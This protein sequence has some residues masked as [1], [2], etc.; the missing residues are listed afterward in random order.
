[1]ATLAEQW[2]A[3]PAAKGPNFE[4]LHPDLSSRLEQAKAAYR[5]Q[6]GKDL[7]ITS[8]VRSREEQQRLYDDFKA[9]KPGIYMPTNPADQ[10]NKAVYH[11]DAVDI[12]SQVPESFLNQHGLHRP[13]GKKDPV[14]TVL[15]P[16]KEA[17]PQGKTL[18]DLWD[19]TPASSETAPGG[20]PKEELPVAAQ[21]YNQF[22]K[23]KRNI[24]EGIVGAGETAAQ[25]A[26]GGL[27]Y[28]VS[29]AG[30]LVKALTSGKY[31][32][33]EG[34]QAGQD[35]AR[36]I[37]EQM[38]YQPRTQA[39]Q[40][41]SGALGKAFEAS[42]LPPMGVPEL[43]GMAPLAG[44]AVQQ[45]AGKVAQIPAQYRAALAE[46][47]PAQQLQQQFQAKGGMRSGGAA[48]V[49]AAAELEAAIAQATP[50]LAA[51]LRQQYGKNPELANMEA[52]NRQLE[53]DQLLVPVRYTQG[54]ASQNP[55]LI[56]KERN[57]RGFKD[58]FVQRFNEQNK[59]LQ[60]NVNLVKERTAP[61]VFGPDYVSN[62]SGAIERI[63]A[64]I[65]E[66]VAEKKQA[67]KN[68]EEYGAGKLEID[69]QTFAN[70]ALKALTKNEDIDFLPSAIKSKIDLYRDGKSM[71]F[72]QY[73]NL[74]TQV[75]R[76][77]IKAAKAGDGNAEYALIL[78][79][80]EL[81]KLP[82]LNETA[83]AKVLADVARSLAKREFDLVDKSRPTYNSAFATVANKTAD[84]SNFIQNQ[85]VRS[86][87]KD[88]EKALQLFGN[89]PEAIQNLRA[90]TLDYIMRE[91]TDASGNFLTG[92]FA[93]QIKN[94]DVN[95]KLD[96]LYGADDAK[97]LRSIANV[98]SNIEARPKGSFVN[99]SNSA[100]ALGQM[101][102]QY[103]SRMLE[104]TPVIGAI[105]RPATELFQQR[106]QQKQIKEALRPGAGTKL[107]DIGKD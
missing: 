83:E 4:G 78:T 18:G 53:A 107:S 43:A 64:K 41:M 2:D 60:E 44:P 62:A 19:V 39:G 80:N 65:N 92:K 14:H 51:D 10:P 87:N 50:E 34:V 96:A 17:N 91:S 42:K 68:L 67:Y 30:G 31:G 52:I 70:N 63:D 99:E 23:V 36:K 20:K 33:Q 58:Q 45:A 105:V 97:M 15:M 8:G 81:E 85:I 98:G 35:T 27:A 103:G 3:A 49:P 22:Q 59:A 75:E 100:T 47:T 82:L 21:L 76:E 16:S 102:K 71:N 13:L 94:L 48:A 7:P 86:K 24:G 40:E 37:Q 90:G 28:P 46:I 66:F 61:D 6:F 74:I 79:R 72:D 26:S 25:V 11:S 106:K 9:G 95:K 12:S 89:D 88:F 73:Q 77:R 5:Q 69:S 32:T 55:T 38:I 84:T 1:M 104:E 93:K 57:E 54:Q 56:S 101:A 29:A